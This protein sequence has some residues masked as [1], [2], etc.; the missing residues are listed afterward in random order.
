MGLTPVQRDLLDLMRKGVVPTLRPGPAAVVKL[1]LPADA[2]WREAHGGKPVLSS[3]LE[4]LVRRGLVN[5]H[6][7]RGRCFAYRLVSDSQN[8]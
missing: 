4:A 3:T 6:M 1:P 5:K 2:A 8:F 7:G